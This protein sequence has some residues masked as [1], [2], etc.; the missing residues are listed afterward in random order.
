MNFK[1]ILMGLVLSVSGTC[2]AQS[3]VFQFETSGDML[4]KVVGSNGMVCA[5][6]VNYAKMVDV[7]SGKI[8]LSAY[9]CDGKLENVGFQGAVYFGVDAGDVIIPPSN[10]TT[11]EITFAPH[12]PVQASTDC[13]T[14]DTYLPVSTDMGETIELTGSRVWI[15][16]SCELTAVS[17]ATSISP[18]S[19]NV[20]EAIQTSPVSQIQLGL[21]TLSAPTDIAGVLSSS[22]GS[23]FAAPQ[24]FPVAPAQQEPLAMPAPAE[25][26]RSLGLDGM[27]QAPVQQQPA[28]QQVPAQQPAQQDIEVTESD[29][30]FA[31]L[32]NGASP[33]DESTSGEGQ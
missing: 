29:A 30:S 16:S 31:D 1:S 24:S 20:Q 19:I 9:S 26:S 18:Q 23:S 22:E 5:E 7:N 4:I 8:N 12:N 17:S 32:L 11:V 25:Q 2:F 6:P 21:V 14:E 15:N 10:G 27:Q 28:T 13:R 33:V 3:G